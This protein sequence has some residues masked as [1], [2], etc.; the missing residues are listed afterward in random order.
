MNRPDLVARIVLLSL[1]MGLVTMIVL[2]PQDIF[3][4]SL[5]GLGASGAAAA[6]LVSSLAAIV[7]TRI[8]ISKEAGMKANPRIALHIFSGLLVAFVLML[9][10]SLLPLTGFWILLV[11]V[12]FAYISFIF[13]LW[14]MGEFTKCDF[15]YALEVVNPKRMWSYIVQELWIRE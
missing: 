12:L 7:V 2:I 4:I 11:Y 10:G 15:E 5:L 14:L 3:G 8:S 1:L 13:V 9:L 6:V